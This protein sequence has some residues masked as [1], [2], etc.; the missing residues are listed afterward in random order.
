MRIARRILSAI[1]VLAAAC[2]CL[3]AAAPLSP[4]LADQRVA[5]VIGISNYKN[6]TKLPNPVNDSNAIGN[7]LKTAGFS[8]EIQNDLSNVQMRRAIND[9]AYRVR[10]ADIALVF[11]AGHGIEVDGKNYLI[12]ADAV[13]ERDVDVQD[14]TVP[15]DRLLTAVDPASRLR[16]IFLDACRDNPFARSM[17]RTLATRSLGRGLANVDLPSANTLIAF[18]AK[19]GSTAADGSEKNSPFTAALLKHVTAPG[20][21]LRVALGRVRDEVMRNTRNKQEPFLYSSWGGADIALVEAA[22]VSATSPPQPQPQQPQLLMGEA[23]QAWLMI[24]DTTNPSILEA[25]RRRFADTFYADLARDRLDELARK[26]A[27]PTPGSSSRPPPAPGQKEPP[28]AQ[29]TEPAKSAAL[30]TPPPV[31]LPPVSSPAVGIFPSKR[32]AASLT[33]VEERALKPKDTF[34]ECDLCPEMIVVPSGSFSMGSPANEAGRSSNEGPQHQVTFSRPFSVSR[35]AVTFDEWDACAA[36]GG[37]DGHKPADQGWGRGRRPAINVSWSNAKAYID[38]L[39]RKTGKTYRL[40]SEAEAEYVARAGSSTPFWWGPSIAASQANYDGREVYG[41][42]SKGENRQKTVPVDSFTA[43]PWGLYQVH[44]NVWTWV[45]DCWNESYKGA[46]IDGSAWQSGLCNRR[47]LRG[48]GWN[49]HPKFLRA[50]Y[51][52]GHNIAEFI[53]NNV[54]VR[55]ARPL[56]P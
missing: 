29:K 53:G 11:Y 5:L 4:A 49:N 54:G 3:L 36:D 24:R 10:G 6:V 20:V 1:L 25:F 47:I 16:L 46:P 42:G 48:G 37:C 23:A 7:L 55:V 15:L 34:K 51:R 14:E 45:E 56:T 31:Q 9:F 17:K 38:W 27:A 19:A 32:S 39:S 21:D 18:A 22:K 2:S 52:N 35:F 41:A 44:G 50:A 40:L 12:P 8:V 33:N 30:L 43:N 13:L 28:V 26:Q